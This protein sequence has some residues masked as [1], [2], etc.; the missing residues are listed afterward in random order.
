MKCPFCRSELKTGQ[1]RRFETLIEHGF[2]PNK[3]V[4][5]LRPTFICTCVTSCHS[6]WTD[7]GNFYSYKFNRKTAKDFNLETFSAIGSWQEYQDKKN[8]L[9]KDIRKYLFFAKYKYDCSYKIANFVFCFIPKPD[10]YKG[11]R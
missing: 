9:A 6:F 3:E 7:D 8:K 11:E 4:Y 2:E 10:I 5:P 1:L